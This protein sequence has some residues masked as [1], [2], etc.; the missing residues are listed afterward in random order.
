MTSQWVVPGH[1]GALDERQAR[2]GTACVTIAVQIRPIS[3]MYRHRPLRRLTAGLLAALVMFAQTMAIAYPCALDAAQPE[4]IVVAPC[5]AHVGSEAQPGPEQ[6]GNLCEVH[7]QMPTVSD[8]GGKLAPA[9]AIDSIH[10]A[11]SLV[12]P[13]VRSRVRTSEARGKPPPVLLRSTR[14]LI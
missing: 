4:A 9:V 6:T 5:P 7:C 3:S 2:T 11:L 8:A 13:G 12:D 10:P 14:L 1:S